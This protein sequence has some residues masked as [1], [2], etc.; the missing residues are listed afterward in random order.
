MRRKYLL[1]A[2]LLVLVALN[3]W[4]WV[5]AWRGSSSASKSMT[6]GE[7]SL[8]FPMSPDKGDFVLKRDLFQSRR[9]MATIKVPRRVPSPTQGNK[10]DMMTPT[11][12]LLW[13]IRLE[14][15]IF[16][17]EKGQAFLRRS[18]EIYTVSD[19]DEVA[20]LY[21]VEKIT[22]DSVALKEIATGKVQM[23]EVTG[24]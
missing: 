21:R 5:P 15:V 13:G 24:P 6:E 4:R 2:V 17:G 8:D 20:G 10:T 12:S 7:F 3:L 18:D 11:P 9:S 19:G 16:R 14:G 22:A 23:F 1:G